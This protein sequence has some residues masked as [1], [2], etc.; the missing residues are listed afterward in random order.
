MIL[1]GV[2]LVTL[3]IYEARYGRTHGQRQIDPPRRSSCG[4]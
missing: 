2:P 3:Q 1:D 4:T